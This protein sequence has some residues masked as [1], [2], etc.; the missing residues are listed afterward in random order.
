MATHT[1][2]SGVKVINTVKANLLGVTGT[3]MMAIGLKIIMKDKVL[4]N[5]Q[6]EINMSDNLRVIKNMVKAS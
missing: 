5:M 4:L 3:Y 2:V 6:M 1:P